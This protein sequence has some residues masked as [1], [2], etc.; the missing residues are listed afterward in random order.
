[1]SDLIER[2]RKVEDDDTYCG[3]DAGRTGTCHA[4]YLISELADE[5]ERLT[6]ESS[7]RLDELEIWKGRAEVWEDAARA[8]SA[9]GARKDR[10]MAA[11][12]NTLAGTALVNFEKFAL[13]WDRENPASGSQESM[14]IRCLERPVV[15]DGTRCIVCEA[16]AD[17][18]QECYECERKVNY[19][20]PDSRC[21]DC[22]RVTP[23]E[24]R[25]DPTD[26]DRRD[27]LEEKENGS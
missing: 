19:L 24:L 3:V 16:T 4:S 8:A 25:G 22:T 2:A 6:T 14:C 23:E 15:E 21:G 13:H 7:D 11:Y 17:S 20:F 27:S 18:R 9:E 5:I 10:F 12:K 26:D 1:M